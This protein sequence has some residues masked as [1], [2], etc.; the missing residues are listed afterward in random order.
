MWMTTKTS[1]W[2]GNGA[3]GPVAL[4]AGATHTADRGKISAG[5]LTSRR[6]GRGRQEGPSLKTNHRWP[7]LATVAVC[8]SRASGCRT[9]CG[10]GGLPLP[11]VLFFPLFPS[12]P[13]S[14][15]SLPN[16]RFGF[17]PPSAGTHN[18][19]GG[20]QKSKCQTPPTH[21]HTNTHTHEHTH[22]PTHLC[23]HTVDRQRNTPHGGHGIFKAMENGCFS[24]VVINSKGHSVARRKE[25][26]KHSPA[27]RTWG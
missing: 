19:E 10:L 3:R 25:A 21:T 11:L 4:R 8:V 13:L 18:H 14:L 15:C 17:D 9:C 12:S 7:C 26:S 1:T 27:W 22:T 2:R 6:I 24:P 5:C 20:Q 16:W 23:F